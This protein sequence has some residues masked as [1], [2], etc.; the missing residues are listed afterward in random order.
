ML[1]FDKSKYLFNA[2]IMLCYKIPIFP[3]KYDYFYPISVAVDMLCRRCL[4][5][6]QCS[7]VAMATSNSV[8]MAISN[9]VT[10][11][12][13]ISLAPKY[14][15]VTPSRNSSTTDHNDTEVCT[16]CNV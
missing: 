11:A 16:S 4:P 8:T 9:S 10:M 7:S 13:S 15:T 14:L 12:T 2:L 6:L 1:F 5:L 3:V